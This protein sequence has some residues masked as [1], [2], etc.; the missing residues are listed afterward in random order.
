MRTRGGAIFLW[1][2]GVAAGA[3]GFFSGTAILAG[4]GGVLIAAFGVVLLTDFRGI[5]T[6]E[7]QHGSGFG[8]FRTYQ[9]PAMVRLI[10]AAILFVGLIW[11]YL[12]F[13]KLG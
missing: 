13:R 12:G 9:T 1:Y 10:G 6:A 11:A 2:G 4:L 3:I 8:P 7:S 5:A